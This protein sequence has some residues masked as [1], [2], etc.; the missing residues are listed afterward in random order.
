MIAVALTLGVF[1]LVFAL[2]QQA[3]LA[4]G[5]RRSASADVDRAVSALAI[6][7]TPDVAVA[8]EAEG[9][10]VVVTDSSGRVLAAGERKTAASPPR[11]SRRPGR[12]TA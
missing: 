4:D 10:L 6:G 9:A 5:P 3:V 7:S 11:R 8:G 12:V 2:V 1:T